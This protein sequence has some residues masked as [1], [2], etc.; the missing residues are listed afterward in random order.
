LLEFPQT[1][2]DIRGHKVMNICQILAIHL[3]G[4][5]NYGQKKGV[6]APLLN[7]LFLIHRSEKNRVGRKVDVKEKK[8]Y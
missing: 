3:T 2:T 6:R 5:K 1:F 8:I 7:Y 4:N